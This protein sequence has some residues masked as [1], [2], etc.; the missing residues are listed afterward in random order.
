MTD[1][2]TAGERSNHLV[3]SQVILG[4]RDLAGWTARLESLGLTVVD[5][6][7]HPGLGTANRIVPLDAAYFE[8]LGVVDEA[9]AAAQ[10]YGQSLLARIADGD[11]LVRWSLRTDDIDAVGARLGLTP[12]R[13]Q[14][15]RPDGLRLTW[16]AAGLDLALRESWLPFFM[17]WDDPVQYPGAT[18]KPHPNGTTGVDWL[19]LATDDR[20]RLDRWT[21]NAIAPLRIVTGAPGLRRVALATAGGEIV[22]P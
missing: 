11:C 10:V 17:Q 18:P 6:G 7:R 22:I 12:E 3:I 16:R 2:S 4:T 13:R 14:R 8:V 19:E 1:I 15:V 5:G 9:E 21:E 20:A